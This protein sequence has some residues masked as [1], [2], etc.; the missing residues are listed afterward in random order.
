MNCVENGATVRQNRRL[1]ESSFGFTSQV[2]VTARPVLVPPWN[3]RLLRMRTL[4]LMS[5]PCQ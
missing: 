2:S 1:G 4:T 5:T 3:I